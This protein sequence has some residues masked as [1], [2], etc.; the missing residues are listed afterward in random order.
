M[1]VGLMTTNGN[2]KYNNTVDTVVCDEDIYTPEMKSRCDEP[3]AVILSTHVL[4]NVHLLG[5]TD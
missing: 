1:S 2:Y 5:M 3:E 4:Q